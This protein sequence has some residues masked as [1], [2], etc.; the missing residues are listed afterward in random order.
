[1]EK[2]KVLHT[3]KWIKKM[4]YLY[5]ME[6]YSAMKENETGEHHSGQG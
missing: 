6:F 3:G 5:R 1:M 4:W 2:P